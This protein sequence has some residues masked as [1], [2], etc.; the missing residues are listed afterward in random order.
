M[1]ATV[2]V[3]DFAPV[4]E[5][6]QKSTRGEILLRPELFDR[7]ERSLSGGVALLAA[8]AGSGK[9]V[10]VRSWLEATQRQ[11]AWV[12][13]QRGESDAQRFWGWVIDA[14]RVAATEPITGLDPTPSFDGAAIVKRL[15]RELGQLESPLV[16]VIDDLHELRTREAVDQLEEF[17]AELPPMLLVVLAS[18]GDHGLR[19]HRLRLNGS[20]T[21]LRAAD[22]RLT[23]EQT[24]EVLATSGA[25]LAE[26]DLIRLHELTEGWPAGV[27]LA[28]I[29]LEGHTDPSGFVAEFSGTERTV[30]EYL[31]A[32][33]LERQPDDVKAM[34]LRTSILE[35]VSGPL[36]DALTGQLGG[37]ATLQRLEAAGAFVTALG[38]DRTWFRYHHLFA[39]LL[40]LELRRSAPAEVD[41]LH[42]RAA[43]WFAE[44]GH[45][46]E[47]I[48]HNQAAGQWPA[49]VA[50]LVDHYF[51]LALDGRQ[52][53]AHALLA[54]FPL[55]EL[56]AEPELALIL[57]ADELAQGSLE[58]AAAQISLAERHALHVAAER[59]NSFEVAL[60]F[61]RLSLARRRGDF[62]SVLDQSSISDALGEP[63]NWQDIARHDDL[64]AWA[65]LNLGIVESW[66]GRAGDGAR[67][68]KEAGEMA[69]RIG[70]PYLEVSSLAHEGSTITGTSFVLAQAACLDAIA[71]AEQ[72]GWADDPVIAPAMT[73][74]AAALGQNGRFDEAERWL[75]RAE[76]ALRAEVEPAV[77]FVLFSMK[78]A[79]L[80]AR[81]RFLEA[82]DVYAQAARLRELLVVPPALSA[83]IRSSALLAQL[84]LGETDSV[85]AQLAEVAEDERAAGELREVA[86]RL[87]LADDDHD[88]AL[89]ALRPITS[90][91]APIH[92]PS[93][94]VRAH[95]LEAAAHD[96]LGDHAAREAA[97]ERALELAAPD[98][99]ILPFAHTP[100]EPLL[101]AHP[102][103]RTAHGAFIREILDALSGVSLRPVLGEV[104]PLDD[105]LTEVELRVL[106]FLP[107][108]LTAAEIGS[109]LFVSTNTVKTH[110]R[111]IY[112]KLGA[113]SRAQALERARALGLLAQAGSRR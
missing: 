76:T 56:T 90:G 36:A 23:A 92:H 39:D 108:N 60:A 12:S 75:A 82:T 58:G 45:V 54:S 100:S 27:R 111:H 67:H 88:A 51:S 102:G 31:L 44:H 33:V 86:V 18:R 72:H 1:I 41:E 13:V 113:H 4:P 28:A 68:L 98:R 38:A 24:N 101:A 81:G 6:S 25:Q 52:A 84:E 91:S 2:G 55:D 103:H 89:A 48:H 11:S 93:V 69:R 99:L 106:R 42:G 112:A 70:R 63:D 83:Q 21:E 110:M 30:A 109:E 94:A 57:A 32:E 87:A 107:T 15:R 64:R 53:T 19:L 3:G 29:L 20:L 5:E 22:L 49:A 14:I 59:R 7:L 17:L 96:G 47:A 105:P 73:M 85:R 26:S 78:G 74:L 9:T 50:L 37:E 35:R 34:L 77:G 62:R 97:V 61:A 16:L 46:V 71:K 40:R 79:L 65:L 10:L 104:A 95:I 43:R 8:P 66:S 80:H